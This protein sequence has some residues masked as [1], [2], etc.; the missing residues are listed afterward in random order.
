MGSP[1][2]AITFINNSNKNIFLSFSDLMKKMGVSLP[3]QL[4]TSPYLALQREKRK[5]EAVTSTSKLP[6]P[7][8]SRQDRDK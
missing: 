8:K 3:A 1:G 6:A 2:N 4:T 5:R 7:K